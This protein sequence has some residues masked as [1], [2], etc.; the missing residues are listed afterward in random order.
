MPEILV[1]VDGSK[2]SEKIVDY[3]CELALKLSF[4][5]A[6]IYVSKFPDLIDE[7]IG[8]GGKVPSPKAEP[9]VRIAEKVT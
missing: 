8:V 7:Y 3:A 1:A 2:Y 4:Q 9:Y 6:L 5:I